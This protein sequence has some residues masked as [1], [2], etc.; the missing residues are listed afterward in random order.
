MAVCRHKTCMREVKADGECVC[1]HG[2]CAGIMGAGVNP[3]AL[4]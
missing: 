2:A 3:E 1:G 4:P